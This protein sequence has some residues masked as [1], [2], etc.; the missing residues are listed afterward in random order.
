MIRDL[1]DSEN[2][3]TDEEMEQLFES[4]FDAK[5]ANALGLS[6]CKTIIEDHA[7]YLFVSQGTTRGTMFRLKLPL[8]QPLS[9][10]A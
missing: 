6:L 1:S 9:E 8:S 2:I 4:V 10:E 3:G 7:G 5:D